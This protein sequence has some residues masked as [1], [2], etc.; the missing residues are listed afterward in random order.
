MSNTHFFMTRPT[1]FG[2]LEIVG[3][4][5][6]FLPNSLT[7]SYLLESYIKSECRKIVQS[8]FRDSFCLSSFS[9]ERQRVLYLGTLYWCLFIV[10]LS[11]SCTRKWYIWSSNNITR[12]NKFNFL[13]FCSQ[14]INLN[15]SFNR[16][17]SSFGIEYLHIYLI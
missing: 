2:L 12:E 13:F 7:L 15:K 10:S 4:S 6:C 3:A 5:C 8:M 1:I 9:L 16:A 14:N 17:S 11:G